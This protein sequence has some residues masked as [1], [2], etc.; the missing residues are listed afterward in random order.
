MPTK[1]TSSA[2]RARLR[3]MLALAVILALAVMLALALML[4]LAPRA[5]H[6]SIACGAADT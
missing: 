4:A 1:S 2:T 5:Q 3:L 6:P